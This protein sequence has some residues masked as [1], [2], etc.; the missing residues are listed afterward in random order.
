MASLL[1]YQ[2]CQFK[3]LDEV[4]IA[5]NDAG[6]VY[7]AT[8]TDQC[9]TYHQKPFCLPEHL[10]RFRQSCEVSQIPLAQSDAELAA[11]I[12]TLLARN[13]QSVPAQTEWSIIWLA[14]PGLVGSFLGQSGGIPDAEPQLIVYCFPLPFRRFRECYTQGC[15]VRLVSDATQIL[16]PNIKHR[17]R[18][19]WWVANK[20][21]QERFPKAHVLGK[22]FRGYLTETAAAN[23]V[24]IKN[25][26]VFSPEP[27]FILPG[28]S[29]EVTRN[30]CQNLGISFSWGNLTVSDLDL[31]EEAILCSTPYGI[32]PVGNLNGRQLPVR[33]PIFERL[34]AGWN[35][36]VGLELR[37]QFLSADS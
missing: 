1:A 37:E 12:E 27:N 24:L 36:L 18:L 22:D 17:S 25:G 7:G 11:I 9:R 21:V 31:A 32:A 33:G 6:F 2:S 34:L 5:L 15:E 26:G 4:S 8:A 29:L 13:S 35:D 19:G 16:F 23:F 28:V 20:A 14:M 3:P 30:L 10:L